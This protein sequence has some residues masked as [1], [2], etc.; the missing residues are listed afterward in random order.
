[1]SYSVFISSTALLQSIF[2]QMQV[3]TILQ[4]AQQSK[5]DGNKH[6]TK[7][8]F[9]DALRCYTAAIDA[10]TKEIEEIVDVNNER[11]QENAIE[12]N[13][14]KTPTI[15]ITK[16][17]PVNYQSYA[18]IYH[19]NRAACYLQLQK[20]DEVIQDCTTALQFDPRYTKALLRRASA[21]ESQKKYD[22][23]LKGEFC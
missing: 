4:E 1:M 14:D 19:A 20:F 15:K 2:N 9:E 17:V 7:G 5:E 16:S 3:D 13:I 21:Y 12:D 18:T 23:A 10:V 11:N 6:Y 8:E 22:S